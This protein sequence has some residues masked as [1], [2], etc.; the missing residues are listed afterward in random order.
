MNKIE[1]AK[2]IPDSM[3]ALFERKREAADVYE[4]AVC[5]IS[6]KTNIPKKLV[7]EYVRTVSAHNRKMA[8]ILNK[9]DLA[10][11]A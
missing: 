4:M 11:I 1:C 7:F 10:T 5:S 6:G 9:I 3:L 8:K 2:L